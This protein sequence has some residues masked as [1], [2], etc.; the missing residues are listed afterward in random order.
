MGLFGALNTAVAGMRAQSFAL[1]NESGNIANSQT[2]GF[3][4]TDTSFED[5]VS[6]GGGSASQ[7]QSGSV[8]ANS[9]ATN[10]V[11]GD[12]QD[13]SVSTYMAINGQGFFVVQKPD[14]SSGDQPTFGGVNLYTRRGDFQVDSN[15]YLVNGAGY[16]LSGIPIDPNTGN[17]SSS[18]PQ[19]L[20][21]QSSFMP[22]QPTTEVDYSA[23]LAQ[24]PQTTEA[25]SS[26]PG[27]ELL[28]LSKYT[29]NPT[30]G[31]PAG[32]KIIGKGAALKPDAPATVT[33]TQTLPAPPAAANLTGNLTIT[34]G[35]APQTVTIAA[36]DTADDIATKINTAVGVPTFAD[37]SSGHLV[38]TGADSDTDITLGG[39][40]GVLSGLGLTAGTTNPT[41]LITQGAVTDGQTLTIQV[42]TNTPLS[43]TFSN[44]GI[45]T[46][47]ELNNALTTPPGLV[48]GTA[49]IDAAGNISVNA[50][51][52]GDAITIGGTATAA[53]FGINTLS[54]IPAKGAVVADDADTFVNESISGGAVTAYDASGTPTNVQLRWAKVDSAS[55]G[56]SHTDTWN[57][58]YQTDSNAT[59][60]DPEWQNAG[61]N[62]TFV[63][64]QLSPAMTSTALSNVSVNGISLGNLTLNFGAGGLTQFA[65]SHGDVQVNQLNANG[66]SAGSLQSVA[67]G[68]NGL[69]VGTF[70]NGR[71]AT[72][73]QVTLANF[74]GANALQRLDGGAYAQTVGSGTPTFN[75]PGEI[76]GSALESS[77]V[78]IADEFTKL[79]VTQQAY[80][81]NTRVISTTNQMVQ[82]LLNMLR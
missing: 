61:L 54:A 71:T 14:S 9:V 40:S 57:L 58:F 47:Q 26:V 32:A 7:Q 53:T 20:Q 56:G 51:G 15:G 16:Y 72:M 62:F 63:N 11:Q 59:G 48:G 34:Y 37:A 4:G 82:D 12:V 39:D 5:M 46:L 33:A 69:I 41:N 67:V 43:I 68:D 22:A 8:N 45:K 79:I 13:A 50:T 23:N 52:T 60:T 2:T 29:A 76:K 35:G 70:S 31:A 6:G 44:S 28:D 81:A 55:L 38:L 24:F 74:S 66:F 42:G 36:T 30:F 21:F 17:P 3:K 77:N 65:D 25:K 19:V 73:A 49:S 78:D 18:T 64:N 1:Q 80:S 27:S 10:T 75:A